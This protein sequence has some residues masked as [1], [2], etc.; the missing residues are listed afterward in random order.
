MLIIPCQLESYRSLKDR[1]LK[2]VFETAEPNPD[3]S[4]EIQASLMQ[5]GY[6]AFNR[7]PFSSSQQK[8]IEEL[9]TDYDDP[10]KT[11][12]KRL[13][14]VLYRN[15]EQDNKG[16]DNFQRYYDIHMEQII[17]HFKGKLD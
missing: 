4:K 1:T 15:W 14:A 13:R 3:Q 12:S 17:Q 16:Y 11:P 8:F 6:L 10:G 9:K 5:A 7:D 2:L